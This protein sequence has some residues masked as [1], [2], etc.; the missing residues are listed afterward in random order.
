MPNHAILWIAIGAG[1]VFWAY[2]CILPIDIAK[3]RH[4]V[5]ADGVRL[6]VFLAFVVPPLWIAALLWSLMGE[7][8]PPP[9]IN[10]KT[11]AAPKGYRGSVPLS[12]RPHDADQ[13]SAEEILDARSDEKGNR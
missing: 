3:R 12:Y 7:S 5:S 13:R 10:S 8:K 2:L 11:A 1:V 4:H 9:P 6:L